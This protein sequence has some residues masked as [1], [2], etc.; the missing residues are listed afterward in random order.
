MDYR[1]KHVG[2]IVNS[3]YL[4]NIVHLF[5]LLHCGNGTLARTK[6][7]ECHHRL[8]VYQFQFLPWCL[9]CQPSPNHRSSTPENR[10]KRRVFLPRKRQSVIQSEDA[11]ATTRFVR[12]YSD[13]TQTQ[14]LTSPF[15]KGLI[16]Q[17]VADLRR[18]YTHGANF[19][20]TLLIYFQNRINSL[21]GTS[22]LNVTRREFKYRTATRFSSRTHNR[23]FSVPKQLNTCLTSWVHKFS[24]NLEDIK[25]L[26]VGLVTRNKAHEDPYILTPTCKMQSPG[27]PGS[28]DLC[29][30]A[31]RLY[32]YK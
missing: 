6:D 21:H 25:V 26:G 8:S 10:N 24:K 31:L 32:S 30:S 7:V 14:Q 22:L 18:S 28:R 11:A 12:P 29:T 17:S 3:S 5:V 20:G 4:V 27:R 1:P 2:N 13:A 9:V 15:K 23:N 16:K 19:Y